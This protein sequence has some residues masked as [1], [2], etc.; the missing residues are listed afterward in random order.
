MNRL[1]KRTH[2]LLVMI[3]NCLCSLM[4]AQNLEDYQFKGTFTPEANVVK[5]NF[6]FN[7]YTNYW[8]DIYRENITYGNLFKMAIPE[9]DYSIAQTKVDMADDLGFSGLSL[10]EGFLSN[11][12]KGAYLILDQPDFQKLNESAGN[13]NVLALIDPDSET[14]KKL[15]GKIPNTAQWKEKL[16]SH[17]F[18][19]K[20]FTEINAFYFETGPGKIF[21]I[22]SKDKALRNNVLKLIERSRDL[23]AKFDLHRGWFGTGSLLKSVTITPGHPLEI[24][25]KGMNEGNS[26]F[27]FSGYMDF[28]AKKEIETWL[29][30]VNLPI[31]TDFGSSIG[32]V[33]NIGAQAIYGCKSYE[34]LQPQNMY[35][36][37]SWLNFAHRNQGYTFRSPYD[38]EADPYHFDG[39]LAGEGNKEQIDNEDIPFVTTT[40]YLEDDA[41]PCMVLFTPK[42]AP[43]TRELMWKSILDRR[44]VG[45]TGSGKMMGPAL[46]RN[47]LELL[48]LD[49]VFLEEY[50]GDR[51]NLEASAKDYQLNIS[52][53]N[54][55][56]HPVSGKLEIVLPPELK[57]GGS[58]SIQLSLA[59]GESGIFKFDIQPLATAMANTNP[60]A[61]HF[62]WETGKK[63]TLTMIDLPQAISVHQLLFGQA[64]KV[65]FPV[66]IH[67]FSDLSRFPVF[68]EVLDKNN[69]DK[70]VFSTSKSCSAEKGKF[71]ELSFDLEVP[72]G[73]YQVRVTA[74]GIQN[75]SQLGV[76][77]AEGSPTLSVVDLNGDGVNEY[78]LENDSVRVVLLATGGRVIEY[79]VKSRK[80]NVLF[81]L[82]PEK[83]ADDKRE[84]RK[85]GYYPFGGFED[86]LGQGSMEGHKIYSAEILKSE[87]NSVSVRMSADYFGNKL[88]KTFTLY[89]NSP[90]LEV[91]YAMTFKNPEAKVIAP[92]P[93]LVLGKKHDTRDIFIVPERDG[94]KEYHMKPEFYF[95]KV[96]FPKEGWDSGYD[97]QEDIAFVGAFPVTRPLFLHMFQNLATNGD[98]H[99][100]F[101]EF[102]PWVPIAQKTTSYFTYYLWGSGG[103]WQNSLQELRDRNLITVH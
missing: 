74:L 40:G 19:S 55:Y 75:L 95:G 70:I 11:L 43:L 3:F 22:S 32:Y 69:P 73:S 4:Y 100:D 39:Y 36:L 38:P 89:G 62:N 35:T 8:H 78:K 81:R 72:A 77:K 82:W 91:R 99:Y 90:L 97:P 83:P 31:V 34:G 25:G 45:V 48:V 93:I 68:M 37:D 96:L 24:I 28:L 17:Q 54:T 92:V 58:R 26:W 46:Y 6:Q 98:A 94:L 64:P 5:T 86:F 87:G 2:L 44:E 20:D 51:I 60:I 42:G 52:L 14:G 29:A 49:R 84:F 61:V 63:S 71:K 12:F 13:K 65:A 1:Y 27:T 79:Y 21:I 88:E 41:L 16:K 57:M 85:R 9:T 23:L 80:S 18:G 15:A 76:G 67:N 30:K 66:T 103:K 7:G 50:F 53:A 56:P 101:N 102:Q 47:A 33:K 59:A 10:Q